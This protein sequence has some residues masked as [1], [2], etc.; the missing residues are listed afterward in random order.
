M[1]FLETY[2]FPQFKLSVVYA[3]KFKGVTNAA[4]VRS[5]IINASSMGGPE[6]EIERE[7][8]NFAFVNAKLIT[9]PLHLQTAIY[10]ALL[11]ESQGLLRTKTIHSEIIWALNPTN[12]ITEAIRRYGVS[13][14]STDL[15]VVCVATSDI[16]DVS[17]KMRDVV[18]GEL[19]SLANVFQLTDWSS[20][21]K[22]YKLNTE[23]AVKDAAGDATKERTV[24]DSIV[25]SSVAMKSAM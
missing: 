24:V 18:E 11:S 6:G 19:D 1:E 14:T 20:V 15:I 9:S 22:H 3:A 25:V 12:N 17:Q 21:K 23:V 8:V 13:D 4:T 5:R 2:R 10:Q 16:P 7:A